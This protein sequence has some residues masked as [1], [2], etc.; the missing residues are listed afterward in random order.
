MSITSI[1]LQNF[2]SYV[3]D[4]FE[5]S[6][7]VNIIVGPNASGK[8]NLL[9]AVLVLARGGSYRAKDAELVRY[10]APWARLDAC[11]DDGSVRTAKLQYNPS[12]VC[13]I[14]FI[15]E[16]KTYLRLSSQKS[17]P[18][19][20]VEPNHLLMLSG[21][22]DLRRSYTD[23]LLEQ[24]LPGF[25]TQRR[26]YKRML[27]QRNA[28][29]KQFQYNSQLARSQIFVWNLRLSELAGAIVRERLALLQRINAMANDIYGS[30]SSR[31]SSEVQ[32]E[33]I[34]NID[35]DQY[36]TAL[37]KRFEQT[38]ERDIIIGFTTAGPHRDDLRVRLNGH[39]SQ[40]SAS[41]GESRTIILT[42]KIIE[43]QLIE[44]SREK[45]PMLLLD[46]VFSE[47]DG[48]RRHALTDYLQAYQTFIT[49]TDAD[50]VLKHFMDA[51]NIIPMGDG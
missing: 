11:N 34:S 35:T 1:R 2:R 4:S 19:V 25:G 38:L 41:R 22:P 26:Q 28:L 40:E 46:D 24:T 20:L 30:I 3:D 15:I 5:L 51:S 8:T 49:T 23:D 47:L 12:G 37:I 31:G 36:E 33:Y 10:E 21:S 44:A 14:S 42:L 45:A 6:T 18:V 43:M 50:V 9:E 7:G 17:L 39:P 27:A 13:K 32:L 16:E 48:K 29:L